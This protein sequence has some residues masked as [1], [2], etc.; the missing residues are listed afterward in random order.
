MSKKPGVVLDNRLFRHVADRPSPENPGRLRALY[1]TL[2]GDI[3]D[4][5]YQRITA[6]PA[7]M[8]SVLAVHSQFYLDQID[9]YTH[10]ADPFAYDRDTY[11]MADTMDCAVLAAGGC[12]QLADAVMD[13]FIDQGFA[14]IRPPGHHAEPGRGMGFCVLNNMAIAAA[15]LRRVHDLR[16]ILIFDFDAHHGNG[17]QEAFYGDSD[18]FVCSIHQH[19]IFP[20]SGSAAEIGDGDG[21]G[22]TL[23]LPVFAQYGDVEYTYLAGRVL[24]ALMEQYLPQIILVSA[25]FDG[26]VEDPIS[27][28]CLST[29][30]FATITRLVRQLADTYCDGRLL[31]VLE[32]GYNPASLEA[33]VLAVLD[34]LTARGRNRVGIPPSDRAAR[35]LD[36]HPARRFWTF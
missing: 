35:L 32:G 19:D 21:L 28:L 14:L 5:R 16:R 31:M 20:F 29:G 18:V 34:A 22:Y 25:G 10:A 24:Q 2:A 33:S 30:W 27:K 1:R 8:E 4:R 9:A 11:V 15:W 6:K 17:I 12:I 3:K 7:E 23:N 36:D 26:H 13:G